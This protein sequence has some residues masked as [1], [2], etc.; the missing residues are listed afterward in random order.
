[1]NLFADYAPDAGGQAPI[2]I[3]VRLV[4]ESDLAHLAALSQQR[5]GGDPSRHLEGLERLHRTGRER[6]TVAETAPGAIVGFG[7]CGLLERP[8]DAPANAIPTGWY[9]TGVVVAPE[10]RRRGVALRLTRDRLDWILER[11]DD[12]YYFASDRNRASIALHERC[13]FVEL[14]RDVWAPG[15]SFTGGSGTL[16]RVTRAGVR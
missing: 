3:T 5:S 1:M 11:H 8:P 4:D 2:P 10:A 6:I 16:Y 9:L 14:R 13:G 7:K 12:A 15:V